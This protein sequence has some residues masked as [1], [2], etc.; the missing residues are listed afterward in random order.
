[1]YI[2]IKLKLLNNLMLARKVAERDGEFI[3]QR[4]CRLDSYFQAKNEQ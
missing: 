3:I 2:D 1:M 4:Y